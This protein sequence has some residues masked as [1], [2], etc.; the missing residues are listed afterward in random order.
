MKPPPLTSM[1]NRNSLI[2]MEFYKGHEQKQSLTQRLF[3]Q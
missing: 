2:Y 3:V 1:I